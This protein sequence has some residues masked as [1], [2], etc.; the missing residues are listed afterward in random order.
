VHASANK[1]LA[2]FELTLKL[3]LSYKQFV[4]VIA[5]LLMLFPS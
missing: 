3:K 2:M 5:M 1:V 4:Q